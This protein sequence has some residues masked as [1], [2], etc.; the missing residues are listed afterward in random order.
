MRKF[1]LVSVTA[2]ATLVGALMFAAP[3]TATSQANCAD[4]F[5][6]VQPSLCGG[7]INHSVTW[8]T[9]LQGKSRSTQFHFLDLVELMFGDKVK[10]TAK[11]KAQNEKNSGLL[12]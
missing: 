6:G 7:K 3:P 4:V 9:W 8:R 1:I 12:L 10:D 5:N 2:V 11:K